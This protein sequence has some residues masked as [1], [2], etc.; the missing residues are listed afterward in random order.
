MA[1]ELYSG[2]Y[3]RDI[4]VLAVGRWLSSGGLTVMVGIGWNPSSLAGRLGLEVQKY[5]CSIKS[6][7]VA[8]I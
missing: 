6:Q 3:N 2:I 1:L 7:K 4:H 5:T 8:T